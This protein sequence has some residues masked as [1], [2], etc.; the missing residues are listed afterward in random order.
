MQIELYGKDTTS[1]SLSELDTNLKSLEKIKDDLP[2]LKT[3][4]Q[5]LQRKSKYFFDVHFLLDGCCQDEHSSTDTFTLNGAFFAIHEKIVGIETL[6]GFNLQPEQDQNFPLK[7]LLLSIFYLINRITSLNVLQIM[8]L[9]E[10]NT[11]IKKLNN[12]LQNFLSNDKTAA[13]LLTQV[14]SLLH[15]H[16]QALDTLLNEALDQDEDS[17]SEENQ[18]VG[19]KQ[20]KE[21]P[22]TLQPIT[23]FIE[24]YSVK[25][26]TEAAV[27]EKEEELPSPVFVEL[28]VPPSP[29]ARVVKPS[30]PPAA[31]P[32]STAPVALLGL[33]EVDI[34]AEPP[35]TEPSLLPP[36]EVVAAAVVQAN[37]PAHDEDPNDLPK[38]AV[39][40]KKPSNPNF[41]SRTAN[42]F[43]RWAKANP[44]LAGIAIAFTVLAL[45]A[46]IVFTLGALGVISGGIIGGVIATVAT[47]STFGPVAIGAMG[48][49]ELA[50]I[51]C[52]VASNS[53]DEASTHKSVKNPNTAARPAAA[54]GNTAGSTVVNPAF[55]SGTSIYAQV[56]NAAVD[57]D[58]TI[59]I[60]IGIGI[61]TRT[62]PRFEGFK[63]VAGVESSTLEP[64]RA[65]GPGIL[66]L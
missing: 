43:G 34:K 50:A 62:G 42:Y 1:A 5:E 15:L 29:A 49:V 39:T 30:L 20:T 56:S 45:A 53:P 44:W 46:G 61:E 22:E 4:F 58:N 21:S 27:A 52:I 18:N 11:C 25:V 63:P 6:C 54:Y 14:H 8:Q 26:E 33:E 37:L 60:G 28:E 55:N 23:D 7:T 19:L 57:V 59:G 12:L 32:T 41:F 66:I 10:D 35:V 16:E 48:G 36:A 31:T 64:V 3:S 65:A 13:L 2:T 38:L 24:K 17:D 9:G 47:S 51:A 40:S